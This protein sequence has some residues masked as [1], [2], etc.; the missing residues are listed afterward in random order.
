MALKSIFILILT[1]GILERVFSLL[2]QKE[3]KGA[4]KYKW[5]THLLM[6][7]YLLCMALALSEFI[8]QKTKLNILVGLIGIIIVVMSAALRK[9]AIK[10]LGDFWSMH[11]KT[12]EGQPLNNS[13]PYRWV[14]HPYYVSV[15]LE[16]AGWTLFLNAFWAFLFVLAVHLPIL[17]Y[18]SFIEEKVLLAFFGQK[19][20]EYRHNV[21]AFFPYS[22][23]KRA[24]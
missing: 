5:T 8:L 9:S 10:S 6:V 1:V 19:Y 17:L 23:K 15:I 12:I 2:T 18:R 3:K 14:R 11:I 16:L 13:G 4:I 22:Y 20:E 24:P 21:T 7:T